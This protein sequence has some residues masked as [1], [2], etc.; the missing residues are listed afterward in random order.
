MW[1][2]P[3]L[4]LV[5]HSLI[6]GKNMEQY[7]YVILQLIS[8]CKL[9]H[10]RKK[11]GL[12]PTTIYNHYY[13]PLQLLPLLASTL[14][15]N[16]ITLGVKWTCSYGNLPLQA[17]PSLSRVYPL[18]QLQVKPLSVSVQMWSQP[19]LLVRHSLIGLSSPV[20]KVMGINFATSYSKPVKLS[21]TEPNAMDSRHLNA[22]HFFCAWSDC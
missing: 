3:P 17:L 7:Y 9:L 6:S 11:K 18:L 22:W 21:C 12:S 19:P 13:L 8:V 4:L 20:Q 2:Q 16:H 1:P 5:M 10:L 14:T 15:A